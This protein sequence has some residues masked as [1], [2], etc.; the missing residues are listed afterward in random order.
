MILFVL[1]GMHPVGHRNPFYLSLR[2]VI[3]RLQTWCTRNV[4][5]SQIHQLS[6]LEL[7]LEQGQ[8][9]RAV[10][11]ASISLCTW[12]IGTCSVPHGQDEHIDQGDGTHL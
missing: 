12:G 3:H 5:Q 8:T 1:S 6:A 9:T 4:A 2:L 7:E 10:V 11:S